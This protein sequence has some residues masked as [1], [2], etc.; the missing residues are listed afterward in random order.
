MP[1]NLSEVLK[2]TVP[3]RV[4]LVAAIWDSIAEVPETLPLT[5]AQCS[6]LDERL[7]RYQAD[8]AAGSPWAEVRE[9]IMSG[10]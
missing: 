2:L 10:A 4:R 5:D 7:A 1:I 3:E 9:R 6:V 8:P